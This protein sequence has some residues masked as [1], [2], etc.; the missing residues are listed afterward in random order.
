MSK[1]GRDWAIRT[2][3]GEGVS[4]RVHG[5]TKSETPSLELVDLY[6]TEISK[7]Y[8]CSWRPVG[9]SEGGKEDEAHDAQV[10]ADEEQALRDLDGSAAT[11]STSDNDDEDGGSG[12]GGMKV[13]AYCGTNLSSNR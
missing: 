11:S 6:L 7:A 10:K 2:M 1:Y 12:G 13:R 5:K 4:A 9:Y 8:G 3:D